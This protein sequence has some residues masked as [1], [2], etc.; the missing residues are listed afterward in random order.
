MD[1]CQ[2]CGQR[3]DRSNPKKFQYT[4]CE[5]CLGMLEALQMVDSGQFQL[6]EHYQ[7]PSE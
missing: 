3:L 2:Q 1:F 4:Y 6:D 5:M 7:K